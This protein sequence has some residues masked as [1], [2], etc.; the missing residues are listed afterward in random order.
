[1]Q[2]KEL[3]GGLA[4]AASPTRRPDHLAQRLYVVRCRMVDEARE[5]LNVFEPA[6]R[7]RAG[8]CSGRLR[9]H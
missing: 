4:V 5:Q 6:E 9:R 3:A 2:E 8:A 1:M 7:C